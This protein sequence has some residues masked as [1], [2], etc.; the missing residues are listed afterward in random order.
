MERKYKVV[1][2]GAGH[3]GCEASLA[4]AR[5]GLKTI[6]ITLVGQEIELFT[7]KDKKTSNIIRG[8]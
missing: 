2:V 7:S 8:R 1:I 5:M 4:C 6:I 3:A